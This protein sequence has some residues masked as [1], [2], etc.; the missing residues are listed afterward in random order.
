MMTE[1]TTT[2]DKTVSTDQLLTLIRDSLENKKARDIIVFDVSEV[3]GVTDYMVLASGSSAPQ[4]K[5]LIT[6]VQ[7][8]LKA[9]GVHAY[10][11]TDDHEAGWMLLDYINVVVHIFE[12]DVREYY[13]LESMWPDA[14][15]S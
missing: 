1:P 8:Q 9:I 5:A 11:R 7:Q 12:D 2:V 4:L 13:D 10:R 3:S 6:E 15:R 14:P